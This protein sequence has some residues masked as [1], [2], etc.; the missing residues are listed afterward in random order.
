M[1]IEIDPAVTCW[2]TG[3][4]C[5]SDLVRARQAGA[6]QRE[7]RDE[8]LVPVPEAWKLLAQTLILASQSIGRPEA[9]P[10]HHRT[11]GDRNGA[12]TRSVGSRGGWP[13]IHPPRRPDDAVTL[14]TKLP[15]LEQEGSVKFRSK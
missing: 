8:Y 14:I 5:A 12:V 10:A 1:V 7:I 2:S 3:M 6:C 11:G 13:L 9:H 15:P 4:R